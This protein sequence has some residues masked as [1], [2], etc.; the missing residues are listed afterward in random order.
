MHQTRRL[1]T[2]L[3]TDNFLTSLVG[4]ADDLRIIQALTNPLG[5]DNLI[6]KRIKSVYC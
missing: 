5:P 1:L 4:Q 3:I 6:Y 2:G